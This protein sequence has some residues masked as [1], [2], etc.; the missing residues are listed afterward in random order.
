MTLKVHITTHFD[1]NFSWYSILS[2]F[3]DIYFFFQNY[4]AAIYEYGV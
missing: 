1:T 2:L 3:A 4:K